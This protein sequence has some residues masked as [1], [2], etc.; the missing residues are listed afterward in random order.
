MSGDLTSG[1]ID[2]TGFGLVSLSKK[3]GTMNWIQEERSVAAGRMN[4]SEYG[5]YG[6]ES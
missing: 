2:I 1:G 5:E 4:A 6:G 3:T